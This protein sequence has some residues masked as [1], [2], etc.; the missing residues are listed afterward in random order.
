VFFDAGDFVADI[1]TFGQNVQKLP[2]KL[3]DTLTQGQEFGR[4]IG[5]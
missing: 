5:G 4:R 2:I 3:V 1:D